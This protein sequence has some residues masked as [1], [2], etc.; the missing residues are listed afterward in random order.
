MT[1]QRVEYLS[2]EMHRLRP[3][4]HEG[5]A[6]TE[7]GPCL[8]CGQTFPPGHSVLVTCGRCLGYGHCYER[9]VDMKPSPAHDAYA[10]AL[11]AEEQRLDV[12][13]ADVVAD[14]WDAE[15]LEVPC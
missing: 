12:V 8:G 9:V 4:G 15:P 10:A 3:R 5:W 7:C 14:L 11:A 13:E 6:K 2:E 1:R